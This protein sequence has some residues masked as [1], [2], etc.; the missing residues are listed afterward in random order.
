MYIIFQL[1]HLRLGATEVRISANDRPEEWLCPAQVSAE[2]M[3]TNL[4]PTEAFGKPKQELAI[5][6]S[7]QTGNRQAS[8]CCQMNLAFWV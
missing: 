8:Y 7:S 2:R 1:M 3:R 5:L 6:E 4:R